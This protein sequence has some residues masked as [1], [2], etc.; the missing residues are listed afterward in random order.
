MVDQNIVQLITI[1]A[2]PV[3]A[4]LAAH[5]VQW[6]KYTAKLD[7]VRDLIDDI[8]DAEKN[9]TVTQDQVNK[10]ISDGKALLS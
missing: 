4:Y 10:I 6:K 7:Q 5:I 9:P 8:D 3:V 1:A 2:P